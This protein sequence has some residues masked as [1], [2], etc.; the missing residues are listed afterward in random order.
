VKQ[1]KNKAQFDHVSSNYE[2]ILSK[3]L[4]LSGENS[5]YFAKK[6]VIH[7]ANLLSSFAAKPKRIMDYGCG[8]GGSIDHLI[9]IFNPSN[10]VAVDT[11]KKS[12]Q[13]LQNNYPSE[14]LEVLQV[15]ERTKALCDL[16][17][18][19]GVFHHIPPVHRDDAVSYIFESL[20]SG[21]F[22]FFWENNPWN[23]AT[24]WVMSRISFDR[25]AIKIFPNQ[26]KNLLK[27]AGF[28]VKIIHY[29]FIF[30]NLLRIFRPFEK[31]LITLPIG[32]QYLIMA[33]KP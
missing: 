16:C 11:S 31:L 27:K 6:R 15:P 19:N 25:D 28:K 17:F 13:L 18:C 22:L 20:H 24:H 33:E 12:L 14:K 2:E 1:D 3:G 23:P 30:P 32:C 10:I 7:S 29:L 4:S 5:T 26:A 8:I 21:G 9:G